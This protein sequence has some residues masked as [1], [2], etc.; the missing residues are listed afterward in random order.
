MNSNFNEKV[1][2]IKNE[3]FKKIWV[4]SVNNR[5]FD[6]GRMRV[7]SSIA[8]CH[9]GIFSKNVWGLVCCF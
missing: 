4:K 8:A 1:K 5:V 3:N 7:M 2:G 9:I 6:L